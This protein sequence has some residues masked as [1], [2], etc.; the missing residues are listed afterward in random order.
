MTRAHR[1]LAVL[2]CVVI[3]GLSWRDGTGWLAWTMFSK[4]ETFRLEISA[5]DA[6]GARRYV[7]PTAVAQQMRGA[8]RTML[9]G[10]ESWRHGPFGSALAGQLYGIAGVACRV[11]GAREVRVVLER[12]RTLDAP[13]VRSEIG[14]QCRR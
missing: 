4:S 2:V 9:A 12:R 7:A 8:L 1:A 3:P 10:A 6:D 14:R 13:V 11:S 5:Q